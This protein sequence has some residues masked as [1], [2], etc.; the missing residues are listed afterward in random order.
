MSA[1]AI[2]AD[3][4]VVAVD[5]LTLVAKQRPLFQPKRPKW[6]LRMSKWLRLKRAVVV[7]LR[8][9]PMM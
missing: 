1:S 9:K 6:W 3:G 5:A 8:V 2:G 7:H 4:A